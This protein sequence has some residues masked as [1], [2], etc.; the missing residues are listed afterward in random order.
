MGFGI[1]SKDRRAESSLV[2]VMARLENCRGAG[3]VD[4]LLVL[5][6]GGVFKQRSFI[7]HVIVR[8]AGSVS[9]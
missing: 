7:R 8:L 6:E 3:V 2:E 5:K 4:G 1:A 9:A